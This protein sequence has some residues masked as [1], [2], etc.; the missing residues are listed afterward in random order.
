MQCSAVLGH[1]LNK[2]QLCRVSE[3]VFIYS[4][5][6]CTGIPVSGN[7]GGECWGKC[8]SGG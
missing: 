7:R 2:R 8:S 5:S 4:I 3:W 6:T 1:T